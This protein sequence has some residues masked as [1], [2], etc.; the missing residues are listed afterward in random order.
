MKKDKRITEHNQKLIDLQID[1]LQTKNIKIKELEL[2]NFQLKKD[3]RFEITKHNKSEIIKQEFFQKINNVLGVSPIFIF[4]QIVDLVEEHLELIVTNAGQIDD[5]ESTIKSMETDFDEEE[6]E[7]TELIKKN[8]LKESIFQEYKKIWKKKK[9][10]YQEQINTLQQRLENARKVNTDKFLDNSSYLEKLNA[11]LLIYTYDN[12][13]IENI[14]KMNEDQFKTQVLDDVEFYYVEGRN[15]LANSESKLTS[16]SYF[17]QRFNFFIQEIE[18]FCPGISKKELFFDKL[19]TIVHFIKVLD[20][21]A[22][23]PVIVSNK[24]FNEMLKELGIVLGLMNDKFEDN[25]FSYKLGYI[26]DEIKKILIENSLL[27]AEKQKDELSYNI[28][29]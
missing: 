7:I 8:L 17:L 27:K 22:M 29:N 13:E 24:N 28:I 19:D 18:P 16:E 25:T 14:L 4:D 23:N 6:R 1:Q 11:L 15:L 20:K 9:D 5:L 12:D 21:K 3:L 10:D 2:E 26:K